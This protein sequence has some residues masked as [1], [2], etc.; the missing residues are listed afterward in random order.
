MQLIALDERRKRGDII[1]IHTLMNHLEELD[2]EGLLMTR[3]GEGIAK[4]TD[5]E[6][7]KGKS[8]NNIEKYCFLQRSKGACNGFEAAVLA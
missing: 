4:R 1:T 3:E 2:K 5:K 6:T 8:L 7:E